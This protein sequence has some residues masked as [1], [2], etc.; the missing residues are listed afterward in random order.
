[1]E[2][3]TCITEEHIELELLRARTEVLEHADKRYAPFI[4]K[5]IVYGMI[6][7][8]AG[9]IVL[10]VGSLVTTNLLEK[11]QPQDYANTSN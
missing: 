11:L 3:K 9:G 2:N 7:T 8:F 10:G 1:M 6:G 4:I 5:T